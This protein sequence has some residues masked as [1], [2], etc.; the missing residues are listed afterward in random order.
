MGYRYYD[1]VKVK[2]QYPF[3]YGLSYTTFSYKNLEVLENEVRFT[4]TNTGR[5]D[6]KEVVQLYVGGPKGRIFRPEKELKGFKK[7]IL[8]GGGK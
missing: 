7:S 3:G 4:L 2:V 1:T 5:A 8:K 6:G